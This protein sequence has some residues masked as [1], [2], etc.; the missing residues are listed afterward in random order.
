MWP[1]SY[2]QET[3]S[4]EHQTHDVCLE[5]F[6]A[7]GPAPVV[8]T[9]GSV[10]RVDPQDFYN[11]ALKVIAK[12]GVR[13]VLIKRECVPLNVGP[14][15]PVHVCSFADYSLLFRA[16]QCVVH[17]GGVATLMQVIA[18]GKASLILPRTLDQF[19]QAVRAQK[20]GV[21]EIL[22]FKK[23]SEDELL[24]GVLSV[25]SESKKTNEKLRDSAQ[26]FTL[27]DGVRVACEQIHRLLIT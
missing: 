12:L 2:T 6:L 18:A 10:A 27:E 7:S 14:S 3:I 20:L 4:V 26:S 1:G 9:L 22:P 13:A 17:H 24:A 16:C 11:L 21:A 19:D 23:L 25:L 15:M 5:R 8:F